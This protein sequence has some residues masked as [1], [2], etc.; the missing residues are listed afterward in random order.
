HRRQQYPLRRRPRAMGQG[1]SRSLL[2]EPTLSA[3]TWSSFLRT[4]ILLLRPVAVPRRRRLALE[5]NS[6]TGVIVR[7]IPHAQ[8]HIMTARL[9]V[10]RWN[11][12]ALLFFVEDAV[13]GEDRGPVLAVDRNL[14]IDDDGARVLGG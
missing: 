10:L 8:D 5:F 3:G 12:E 14:R 11:G 7:L 6:H 13:V 4:R 1:Q 9:Q 2:R